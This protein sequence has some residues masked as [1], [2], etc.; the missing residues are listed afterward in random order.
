MGHGKLEWEARDKT[1]RIVEEGRQFF[2]LEEVRLWG[3]FCVVE[4]EHFL[5]WYACS[6]LA[7]C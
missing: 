1:G 5:S 3:G 4:F 7:C 6:C 2:R